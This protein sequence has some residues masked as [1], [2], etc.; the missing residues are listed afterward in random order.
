[1]IIH[2]AIYSGMSILFSYFRVTSNNRQVV[3]EYKKG[4]EEATAINLWTQKKSDKNISKM[5]SLLI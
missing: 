1:M 5:L 4:A 2:L 3:D